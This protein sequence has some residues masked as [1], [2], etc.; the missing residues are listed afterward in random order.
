MKISYFIVPPISKSET[1]LLDVDDLNKVI[2]DV[3]EALENAEARD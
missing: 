2:D 3:N 1:S